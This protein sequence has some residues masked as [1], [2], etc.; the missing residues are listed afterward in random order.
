[1]CLCMNLVGGGLEDWLFPRMLASTGPWGA[2]DPL[3][4]GLKKTQSGK[5]FSC[6]YCGKVI[7]NEQT[8]KKHID[9]AH[10]VKLRVS[11]ST[12][13]GHVGV[14]WMGWVVSLKGVD[15]GGWGEL[16]DRVRMATRVVA[17]PPRVARLCFYLTGVQP[18]IYENNHLEL[19]LKDGE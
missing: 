10:Q 12:C 16:W 1:M 5:S 19:W 7:S 18:A 14:A 11:P 4:Q 9:S 13:G 6:F 3:V 8:L 17:A 2:P 15:R